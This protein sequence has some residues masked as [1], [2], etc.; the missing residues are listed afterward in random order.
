MNPNMF[1]FRNIAKS[2]VG[3]IGK[4]VIS[5]YVIKGTIKEGYLRRIQHLTYEVGWPEYFPHLSNLNWQER[6]TYRLTYICR[7]RGEKLPVSIPCDLYIEDSTQNRK[8]AFILI[9]PANTS[10]L[11]C[12]K[13]VS[14][15]YKIYCLENCAVNEAFLGIPSFDKTN[16]T[17]DDILRE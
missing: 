6:L 11:G 14:A 8:T 12:Q 15:L 16:R 4:N 9:D 17:T 5:D 10:Y 7:G 2:V 3:N 1:V 13:Q